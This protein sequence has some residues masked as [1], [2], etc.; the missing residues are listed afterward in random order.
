MIVYFNNNYLIAQQ[1]ISSQNYVYISDVYNLKCLELNACIKASKETGNT[2]EVVV[3][4]FKVL[5][6]LCLERLRKH[7]P[8]KKLS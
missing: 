1:D 8:P 3:A 6:D 5:F 7:L 4:R 2:V